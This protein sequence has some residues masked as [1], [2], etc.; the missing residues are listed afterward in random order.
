ML[1]H[2]LS[3]RETFQVSTAELIPLSGV[4]H[5][6]ARSTLGA[7]DPSLVPGAAV[8]K[9]IQYTFALLCSFSCGAQPLVCFTATL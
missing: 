6:F 2:C 9:E 4:A 3:I 8:L 1:F 7:T 5:D